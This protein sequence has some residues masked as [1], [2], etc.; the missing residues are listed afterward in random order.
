MTASGMP[1]ADDSD[2]LSAAGDAS[3]WLDDHGDV[4]FRYARSRVGHRHLAEDLVQEA[5]LAALQSRD[6]F[7][8]RATVRTWLLSI[9]RHKIIDHCRRTA[10]TISAGGEQDPEAINGP[11]VA[12]YFS[13]TGLWKTALASWKAPDQTLENREFWDVLDGCLSRLPAS[14]RAPFI[15]RELED[16][17]SAEVRR[18]LEVSEANLRVRLHR[19][20]L[21]LRECLDKHWFVERPDGPRRT[22]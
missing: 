22:R 8:G 18:I 12:R 17:D 13:V 4:L 3:A 1:Q 9:L 15:L 21:L 20:R 5:L 2:T 14:L 19:A 16:L 11:I 6:K 10:T 7:Q